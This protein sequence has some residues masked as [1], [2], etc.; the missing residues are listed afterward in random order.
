VRGETQDENP[1]NTSLGPLFL[2]LY[3][4]AWIPFGVVLDVPLVVDQSDFDDRVWGALA[5][6]TTVFAFELVGRDE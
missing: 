5:H 1:Q 3:L 2:P 6:K 4:N